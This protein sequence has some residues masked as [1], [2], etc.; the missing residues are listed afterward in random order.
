MNYKIHTNFNYIC[1]TCKCIVRDL[2]RHMSKDE[3]GNT[4]CY[5]HKNRAFE[6]KNK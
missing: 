1:P 4:R 3:N 6:K 5:R 2:F